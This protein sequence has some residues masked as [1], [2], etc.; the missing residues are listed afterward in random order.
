MD[1]FLSIFFS[2]RAFDFVAG[3]SAVG[4]FFFMP[5]SFLRSKHGSFLRSKQKNYKKLGGGSIQLRSSNIKK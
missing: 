2:Y 1:R 5:P 4:V 3:G